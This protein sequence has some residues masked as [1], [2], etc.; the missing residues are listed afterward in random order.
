M[1]LSPQVF[2]LYSCL[3]SFWSFNLMIGLGKEETEAVTFS[4]NRWSLFMWNFVSE[5][6]L[7]SVIFIYI[8]FRNRTNVLMN[9]LR[10]CQLPITSLNL[11]WLLEPANW[12]KGLW[13]PDMYIF[14]FPAE[15]EDNVNAQSLKF[16]DGDVEGSDS[17]PGQ[18]GKLIQNQSLSSRVRPHC[19]LQTQMLFAD[20]RKIDFKNGQQIWFIMF[21]SMLIF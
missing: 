16:T 13:C 11:K 3:L 1:L 12:E 15:R 4:S 2:L 20:L 9:V 19:C 14:L 8:S 10:H 6:L 21:T 7:Y 5:D 18:A 17:W